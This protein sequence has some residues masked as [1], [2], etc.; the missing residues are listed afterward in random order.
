MIDN[1]IKAIFWDPS[2][3]KVKSYSSVVSQIK[4]KEKLYKSFSEADIKIKTKEFKALFEWLD[5]RDEKDSKKII[6]LLE[7]IKP[8]A[9]ALVKRA[10]EILNGKSFDLENWT[11]LN[12]ELEIGTKII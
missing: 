5:I 4:E 1:I 10:C 12:C 9:F 3:K 11:T 8:D 6:E 2:E 7:S